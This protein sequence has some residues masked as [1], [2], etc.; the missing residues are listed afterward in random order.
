MDRDWMRE[1][2]E[3]FRVLASR[4][5]QSVPRGGI[6]GD[7]RVRDELY[8][9]EPTLRKILKALDP[10]LAEDVDVSRMAGILAARG[11][12]QRALGVLADMDDW[13]TK[14]Q[15]D[16]P[17]LVADRLHPWVWESA[18][19][20]WEA[21]VRQ[22][23]VLTAARTVNARLQQKLNRHDI[24][25]KELCMQSFD[26]KE[27]E[28]GKPRLRFPGDRTTPTWRARQEGAKYFGAGVFMAIRNV[29][30]HQESVSWSEQETLEYLSTLSV[31]ARWI[32]E[33][34]VDSVS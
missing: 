27:P 12:A 3:D 1:Q 26:L 29:A 9:S 19:P 7:R 17:A 8:R 5:E 28:Q 23:A 32:S 25:E 33:C 2:L 4:Y 11:Q 21:G 15:P 6:L 31:L 20:L 18:A 24:S 10:R 22:D 30:A 34:T 13:D 16:A 14:L